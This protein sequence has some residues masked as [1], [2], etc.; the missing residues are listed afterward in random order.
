MSECYRDGDG[1][2]GHEGDPGDM[3]VEP[4]WSQSPS[5]TVFTLKTLASSQHKHDRKSDDNRSITAMHAGSRRAVPQC[6]VRRAP[7]HHPR[8]HAQLG[9]AILA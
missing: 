4:S 3:G 9:L 1:D 5:L 2:G 8:A 6:R 7:L